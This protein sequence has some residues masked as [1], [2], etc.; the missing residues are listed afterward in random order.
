M[1]LDMVARRAGVSRQTVSNA[2]NAPE[3]LRPE[4][5]ARVR[6]AIEAMGYRPHRAAQALRTR[7]S[8]LIGYGVKPQAPG[9]STPVIDGFLHAL[10]QTAEEAGHRILLFAANDTG[11]ETGTGTPGMEAYQEL[12]GTYRVDGFVLSDT[13]LGDRRQA[14]LARH[15]IPFVAFGRMWSG[16][17]VGDFVDVDG[18]AGMETAVEHLVALGHERIAFL[19]WPRG[20]GVGDDRAAGWL[21]AMRRHG[22]PSRGRRAESDDDVERAR[23]AAG[24]LLDAGATAVVAASDTLA[25]GC[26]RALRDRG[27]TPGREVSVAGF[28]DS[29]AAA[30]VAPA[31]TSVAQPLADVGRECVRLLLSRIAAPQRP[32]EHVLLDPAL[33]VRESTAQRRQI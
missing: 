31:L 33:V 10:S 20:S 21:Q 4:T 16:R 32:A 22:L 30:L 23:Q 2:L 13:V 9:V 6:E 26:Y 28:D 14:W 5:L 11:I 15:G 19:G 27:Q 29:P 24:P 18:A 7:S 3:L 12:V 8:R 25:M 17:Q 1:T